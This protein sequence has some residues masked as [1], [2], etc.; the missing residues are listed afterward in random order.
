MFLSTFLVS[1]ISGV[2]P[3]VFQAIITVVSFVIGL[4]INEKKKQ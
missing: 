1:P 2:S 4:F 3:E